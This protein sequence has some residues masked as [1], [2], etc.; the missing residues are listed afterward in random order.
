MCV[1][2]AFVRLSFRF[3]ASSGNLVMRNSNRC[4]C[5]SDCSSRMQISTFRSVKIK[6]IFFSFHI[7]VCASRLL[8]YAMAYAGP[9]GKREKNGKVRIA[10]PH[11]LSLM[12]VLSIRCGRIEEKTDYPFFW[13]GIIFFN[14][15][16]VR[17]PAN[18]NCGT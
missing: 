4:L 10:I 3:G 5:N 14:S 12:P 16:F 9:N 17:P 6:H 18:V 13:R 11:R 8:H 2:R 15:V 7:V 1:V